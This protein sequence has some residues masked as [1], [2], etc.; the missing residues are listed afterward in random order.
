MELPGITYRGAA[1]DD[2]G[3]LEALPV[4]L[5]QLL[6]LRNGFVAFRGGLHVRGACTEPGWHSLRA[7]LEGPHA[8][9]DAYASLRPGD[10]P[11]A[12]DAAG[13]Q[14]ILRDGHVWHLDAELDE[15]EPLELDLTG[16]LRAVHER[17]QELLAFTPLALYEETGARLRPGELLAPWPPRCADGAG[18]RRWVAMPAAE[19]LELLAALARQ[20]RDAP[21]GTPLAFEFGG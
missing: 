17:P 18:P 9:R 3:I 4:P 12:Q 10:V 6:A 13:D 5:Q 7:A 8:F 16:F 14:F 19:R 11:F 2:V 1:L 21:D 20:L 15:L